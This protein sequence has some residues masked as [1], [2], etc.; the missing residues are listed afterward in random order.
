MGGDRGNSCQV[1]A[2]IKEKAVGQSKTVCGRESRE[3][4]RGIFLSTKNSI[5]VRLIVS[6]VAAEG[7]H[8][9]IR[10]EGI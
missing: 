5:E 7:G 6:K 4:E 2:V 10:Y 9:L 3:R 1:I 8:F